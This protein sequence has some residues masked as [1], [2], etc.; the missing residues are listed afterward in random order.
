MENPGDD[1]LA[2]VSSQHALW[3]LISLGAGTL[4][5]VRVV[6]SSVAL[7]GVEK[8]W[9]ADGSAVY[10]ANCSFAAEGVGGRN[11]DDVVTICHDLKTVL[12]NGEWYR[13]LWNSGCARFGEKIIS[14]YRV[15]FREG[16]YSEDCRMS[17][18]EPQE[19]RRVSRCNG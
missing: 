12:R 16:W 19:C 3:A 1:H 15:R 7:A 13:R 5:K 14:R 17:A 6:R 10:S 9:I 2:V 18:D 4:L 11:P 8:F